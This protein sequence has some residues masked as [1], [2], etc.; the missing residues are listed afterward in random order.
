[1][2]N[3]GLVTANNASLTLPLPGVTTYVENSLTCS[4]GQCNSAGNVVQWAGA[5]APNATVN[6]RFSAQLTTPVRDRTP[7]TST[8]QLNDGFG[9][10][11]PLLAVF[12]GRRSDV[13]ASA[14]QIMPPYAEPGTT[15]SFVLFVRNTGSLTTIAEVETAIPAGLIYVDNSLVCGTGVC[16]YDAGTIRWTGSVIPRSL[17]PVRVQLTVPASAPYG[18]LFTS[19]ARVK[20]SNWGDEYTLT[21]T[22]WVA[23][24]LYMPIVSRPGGRYRLYLPMLGR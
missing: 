9:N 14:L 23:H 22:L 6:V 10:I 2:R 5:L 18:T 13:S 1:L 3:T 17:V 19:N 20:D 24:S 21:A 12:L 7:V 11:T 4:S 16:T 8:L 15:V